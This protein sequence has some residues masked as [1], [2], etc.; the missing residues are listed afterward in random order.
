MT[1]TQTTIL[2]VYAAIIAVW[3]VRHVVIWVVLRKLD[4]LTPQ[5]PRF[6]GPEYPLVT[7][8]IPAKD[9]EGTLAD[10]LASVLSQ[11]YPNLE[12]LVVND[13]STDR[14]AEIAD[15]FAA[16]DPR[17]R[18]MTIEELPTGWT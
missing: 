9:E 1:T 13:R 10:C 12:V 6:A 17:V 14:T 8:I 7:A 18:V 5:S 11:T 16:A 3:P 2:W 4:I 15:E